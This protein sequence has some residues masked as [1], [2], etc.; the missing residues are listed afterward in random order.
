MPWR[1][2]SV[3]DSRL[4]V[5]GDHDDLDVREVDP[6]RAHQL[7]AAQAGHGEVERHDVDRRRVQD[8]ERLGTA[9]GQLQ[10]VAGRED[11]AERFARAAF[12]VDDQHVGAVLG[13]VD[14]G[15]TPL[16]LAVANQPAGATGCQPSRGS[17]NP[18]YKSSKGKALSEVRKRGRTRRLVRTE[19]RGRDAISQVPDP[20]RDFREMFR[21]RNGFGLLGERL[22]A[23][24]R[25]P[26]A[27]HLQLQEPA[28]DVRAARPRASGSRRCARAPRGS[29]PARSGRRRVSRSSSAR[30]DR[31][32]QRLGAARV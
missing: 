28:R 17:Q 24:R 15:G 14:H 26:V 7:L 21:T 1:I 31:V 19:R 20:D 2:A 27:V 22:V 5:T 32:A 8:L 18:L 3:A 12:V 6:D 13:S 16:R 11:H 29:A 10:V 30:A 9:R 23:G 4:A 25:D